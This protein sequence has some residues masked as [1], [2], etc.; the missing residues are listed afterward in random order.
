VL[1]LPGSTQEAPTGG[2]RK[3][4]EICEESALCN[5]WRMKA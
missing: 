3:L 1:N 4:F 2:I 5:I